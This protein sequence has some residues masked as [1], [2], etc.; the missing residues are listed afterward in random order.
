MTRVSRRETLIIQDIMDRN[1]DLE[2]S[3]IIDLDRPSL[4]QASPLIVN[5]NICRAYVKT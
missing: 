3:E 2:I 1:L 4:C 5:S